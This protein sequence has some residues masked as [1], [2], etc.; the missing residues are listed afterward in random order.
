MGR[1]RKAGVIR[2]GRELTREMA[3]AAARV[4]GLL[5]AEAALAAAATAT[6]ALVEAAATAAAIRTTLAAVA[7]NVADLAAL[8]H[9]ISKRTF[10]LRTTK[11]YLVALSAGLAAATTAAAT[12]AGGAVTGD[13]AGLA[14]A[15]AGLGVLGAL[16]A[17]TACCTVR[18]CPRKRN[19]GLV[20]GCTHS[21]DP[22]LR[23]A[24]ASC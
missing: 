5:A 8:V 1:V 20:R 16:R 4:A 7:G 12:A 23:T 17:V 14:A 24:K 3:D 19:T 13:V 21:C 22:L 18:N 6:V 10:V 15:V 11:A 2:T 9:H